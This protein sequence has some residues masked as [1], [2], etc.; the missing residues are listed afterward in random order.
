MK[1]KKLAYYMF[2]M[3]RCIYRISDS[4]IQIDAA[5]VNG[6]QTNLWMLGS[7][8][9]L[10]LLAYTWFVYIV[11]DIPSEPDRDYNM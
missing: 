8:Y 1:V 2:S 5:V 10:L 6:L 9:I 4:F 7:A 11:D 3:R